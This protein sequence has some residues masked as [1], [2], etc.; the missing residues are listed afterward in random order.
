MLRAL[1]EC[2]QISD[3]FTPDQTRTP[4]SLNPPR[5][6]SFP[7][8]VRQGRA[9][10]PRKQLDVWYLPQERHFP[11]SKSSRNIW[12]IH[13]GTE[14]WSFFVAIH[15]RNTAATAKPCARRRIG[16]FCLCDHLVT[17]W[18]ISSGLGFVD[19]DFCH[20]QSLWGPSALSNK[21]V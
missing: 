18:S 7:T 3:T 20:I 1:A 21:A 10:N 14:I 6:C 2:L 12:F 17:P 5:S 8:R 13:V 4:N 15:Q 19:K 9:A 16:E 11:G